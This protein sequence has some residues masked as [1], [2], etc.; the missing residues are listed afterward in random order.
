MG[1]VKFQ[2]NNVI[3]SCELYRQYFDEH[4]G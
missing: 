1:L 4:L 2:V 3:S